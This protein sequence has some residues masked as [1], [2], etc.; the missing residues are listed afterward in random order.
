MAVERQIQIKGPDALAFIDLLVT[1]DMK[2]KAHVNQARYVILCNEEGGIINDPV[3]LRVAED[4]IWLSIS[5]SDVLLWAQGVNCGL[6]YDVAINEIDVAPV[7][8]QG[9]YSRQVMKKL[10]GDTI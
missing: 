9:P 5:D 1:R 8:V 7:Q 6:K 2:K 3:L 10:F 4:E